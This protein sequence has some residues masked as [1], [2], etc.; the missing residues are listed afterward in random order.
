MK[1]GN[2]FA[3]DRRSLG[4]F[5]IGLGFLIALDLFHKL[6]LVREFYTDSG[7]M[8]RS[9]WIQHYMVP[10]KISLHLA[11]GE[12]WWQFLLLGIELLAA[13]GLMLGLRTRWSAFVALLLMCSL[14]SRNNLILSAADELMRLMLIWS[15]FVPASDRFAVDQSN[16]EQE[17]IASPGTAILMLQLFSVYIFTAILKLHP[18]WTRD[19]SAIYFALHIDMFAT[20]LAIWLRQYYRITQA[21]TAIVIAWE[22]AGPLLALLFRGWV[23]FAAAIGFILFHLS[24]VL[25]FHLGL[26]P[27]IAITC[28]LIYFPTEFWRHPAGAKL[29]RSL[30]AA[31]AFLQKVFAQARAPAQPAIHPQRKIQAFA[32][33][34]F[35]LVTLNN[36]ASVNAFALA[37]ELR[38]AVRFFYIDQTWNMFAPY[39]MKNDGWF[40]IEGQFQNGDKW[41]LWSG[42][43]VSYEKPDLPSS[44]YHSSEWRKFM[45]QVWDN[46]SEQILLPFARY[47]CRRYSEREGL[48]SNV[49][50]IDVIFIKETTPEPGRP[51]ARPE[52][53]RLWSHDCLKH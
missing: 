46:G 29:E 19:F 12:A 53:V 37:G 49:A 40:V 15:F 22:F 28:W 35:S 3:V 20:P 17:Q 31:F 48:A 14:Q 23:R 10:M 33:A 1:T 30:D 34:L 16:R 21:L 47:L 24:L 32:I 42:G 51:F 26:F 45:L 13:L 39:P 4:L 2:P 7:V 43:P 27:W 9:Y 44:A 41:D 25:F 38:N 36:L 50:L 5:R 8:P 52:P 18:V 11:S 6:F